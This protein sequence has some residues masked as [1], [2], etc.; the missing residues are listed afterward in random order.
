MGGAD[1]G[2]GI[3]VEPKVREGIAFGLVSSGEDSDGVDLSGS[4]TVPLVTGDDDEEDVAKVLKW[5]LLLFHSTPTL[6]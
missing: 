1:S 2:V 6:C 5:S 4:G 3:R